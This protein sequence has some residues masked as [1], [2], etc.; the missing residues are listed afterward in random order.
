[1][2]FDADTLYQLI[3]AIY[4]VRDAALGS[5]LKALLTV[6]AGQT[7]VLEEDLSQLYDDQFIETCAPWVVPYIGDLVGASGL[8]SA[9]LG[10]LTPRAEVARTLGYRRR[11]GTAAVIQQLAH[12]VT[13]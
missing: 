11:K 3:P 13:G 7:A 6:I 12:D 10:T 5:P 4:R 9:T 2:S 1:M 8:R